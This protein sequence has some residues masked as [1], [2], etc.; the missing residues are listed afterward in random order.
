[1]GS[2][3]NHFTV[4]AEDNARKLFYEDMGIGD[5]LKHYSIKI[6]YGL[7]NKRTDHRI[8]HDNPRADYNISRACSFI[9]ESPMTT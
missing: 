9:G 8:V 5:L 2:I 6:D 3:P 7:S 1:M 4:V